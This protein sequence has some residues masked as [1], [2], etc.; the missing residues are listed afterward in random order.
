MIIKGMEIDN[1]KE[2]EDENRTTIY[3]GFI[4][5]LNI[6]L[7]FLLTTILKIPENLSFFSSS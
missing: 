7:E 1:M 6:L 5:I 4:L 3:V 2:Y